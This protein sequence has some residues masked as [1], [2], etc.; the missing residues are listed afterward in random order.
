VP[1]YGRPLSALPQLSDE[2]VRW[3]P[4]LLAGMYFRQIHRR[5]TAHD[6]Y[7]APRDP[8]ASTKMHVNIIIKV[9]SW[10]SAALPC[11][12][13]RQNLFRSKASSNF[14]RSNFENRT[15]WT[16]SR[17]SERNGPFGEH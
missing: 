10:R 1:Q 12:E 15:K 16:E 6:E 11:R 4:S 8:L 14:K 5:L 7:L 3:A 13:K 2:A 17:A 9:T